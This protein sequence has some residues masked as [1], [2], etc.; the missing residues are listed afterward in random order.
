VKCG[1][2]DRRP[3]SPGF[4]IL[5]FTDNWQLAT[6]NLFSPMRWLVYFIFAYLALGLQIGLSP[7]V[8]FHGAE[9]NFALLAVIFIAVNAPRD[10][11]L[12]GSFGIGLI[13]DFLSAQPPGLYALSY[14][15]VAML[16]TG[17]ASAV[18]R[19]HPLAH[20]LLT[21]VGGL[22]TM[23]VLCLHGWIHPP[24]VAVTEGKT[25]FPPLRI[26]AATLFTTVLYTAL[27]APLVIGALQRFKGAFAFRQSRGRIR[28]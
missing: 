20:F 19:Q 12:L 22:I 24:G 6:D 8:R 7:Y 11:A 16:V 27:L 14:G 17:A 25:I 26:P 21:L 23:F 15:I 2:A 5:F 3:F 18:Y 13:Q 4:C 9:P 28:M 1:G 10:A